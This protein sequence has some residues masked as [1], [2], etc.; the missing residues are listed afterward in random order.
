MRVGSAT[1][2]GLVRDGNED[3]VAVG[4][5]LWVVVDGM[6]G[7]EGGELAAEAAAQA[8]L[9]RAGARGTGGDWSHALE[10]SFRAAHEQVVARGAETG[11][12]DMGCVAVLA[13]LGGP[14]EETRAPAGGVDIAWVGDCRAYHLVDGVLHRLTTDHNVAAEL[15]AAGQLTEEQAH[16]HWGQ[17][18]LTRRLGGLQPAPETDTLTVPAKGRLLLCTDGLTIGLRDEAIGPVLAG[19]DPATACQAL[20]G[21]AL[22]AG[23]TDNVSVVVVD[24]AEDGG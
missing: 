7:H 1:H 22:E 24:L 20:V 2:I 9:D 11:M 10:E 21:A 14:V 16:D 8:L 23:G 12:P 6:G 19:G 15:F 3:V 5:D 18:R 17:S 4:D 13:R